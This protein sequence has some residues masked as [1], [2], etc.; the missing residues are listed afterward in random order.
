M[1]ALIGFVAAL[2]VG[3][4][5]C[6]LIAAVF[7]QVCA[8]VSAVVIYTGRSTLGFVRRRSKASRWSIYSALSFVAI[9]LSVRGVHMFVNAW[10]REDFRVSV[11]CWV[12][13]A[14]L[15]WVP[16]VLV[17]GAGVEYL[18]GLKKDEAAHV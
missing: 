9:G 13:A 18:A 4:V 16:A 12:V 17:Y 15:M 11:L 14:V 8:W 10:A 7:A 6:H 2:Y 1:F 5:C 3:I